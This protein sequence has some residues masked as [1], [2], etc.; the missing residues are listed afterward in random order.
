[1]AATSSSRLYCWKFSNKC[2]LDNEKEAS[3][4]LAPSPPRSR[5]FPIGVS[6][7]PRE[8]EA[9]AGPARR[10]VLDKL[11]LLKQHVCSDL[12]IARCT[13][14]GL[15]RKC[16]Q[17]VET[18]GSTWVLALGLQGAQGA[19]DPRLRPSHRI[20]RSR[21]NSGK[22]PLNERFY[23]LSILICLQGKWTETQLTLVIRK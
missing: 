22:S 6:V 20:K 4:S 11:W 19:M 17:P 23:H 2:A 5:P 8:P 12:H 10:Q 1:M 14:E 21:K 3:V 13:G 9:P 15:C 18:A 16:W 7:K